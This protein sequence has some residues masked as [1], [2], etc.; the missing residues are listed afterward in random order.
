ME[1]YWSDCGISVSSY[2]IDE[3][4]PLTEV[5]RDIKGLTPVSGAN[6]WNGDLQWN[7][8][9]HGYNHCSVSYIGNCEV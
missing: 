1:S 8:Y 7:E 9:H 5:S 4:W 3:V 6:R 2:P